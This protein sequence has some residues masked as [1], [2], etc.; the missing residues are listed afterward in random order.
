MSELVV[1]RTADGAI[2]L[3]GTCPDVVEL[4]E[5]LVEAMV[6]AVLNPT[7]A[8]ATRYIDGMRSVHME[9]TNAPGV[10]YWIFEHNPEHDRVRGVLTGYRQGSAACN[11]AAR[12][13]WPRLVGAS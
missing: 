2:A 8:T 9:F 13:Q 7:G 12:R 10:V 5:E 6:G 1:S 11:E 4:A 3:V